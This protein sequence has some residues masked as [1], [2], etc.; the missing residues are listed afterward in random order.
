M[1]RVHPP[2]G[3]ESPGSSSSEQFGPTPSCSPHPLSAAAS[4]AQQSFG[5]LSA[6]V[7][8][9]VQQIPFGGTSMCAGQLCAAPAMQF[10]GCQ[11]QASLSAPPAP[12]HPFPATMGGP[13]ALTPMGGP[14]QMMVNQGHGQGFP[15]GGG[16]QP[17][18]WLPIPRLPAPGQ[19]LVVMSPPPSPTP[20]SPVS[21]NMGCESDVSPSPTTSFT[22]VDGDFQPDQLEPDSLNAYAGRQMFLEAFNPSTLDEG[23]PE[24]LPPSEGSAFHGTSRCS[25]CGWFWKPQG[26]HHGQR[27]RYC[28]LCNEGEIKRRKKARSEGLRR[29]HRTRTVG[30]QSLRDFAGGGRDARR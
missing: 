28:H 7:Q 16:P 24:A 30:G 2:A 5:A 1:V 13:G 19:A 27:C 14:P 6:P 12:S 17:I 3:L 22:S 15:L 29:A 20:M 25:P 23:A 9:P 8:Q 4:A 18:V 11:G 21:F 10:V 26:C